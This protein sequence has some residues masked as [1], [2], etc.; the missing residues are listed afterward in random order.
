LARNVNLCG[1][2][3]ASDARYATHTRHCGTAPPTH[4]AGRGSLSTAAADVSSSASRVKVFVFDFG[5]RTFSRDLICG[6]RSGNARPRSGF[7]RAF[8]LSTL[9]AYWVNLKMASAGPRENPL[10]S[11]E[12]MGKSW[13]GRPGSNRRRPAGKSATSKTGPLTKQVLGLLRKS[14][15]AYVLLAHESVRLSQA[16][17]FYREGVESG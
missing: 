6:K 16:V 2:R 10:K 15:D 13:S 11:R 9:G 12:F 1:I 7:V 4:L 17:D 3:L 5:I 14:S 8:S